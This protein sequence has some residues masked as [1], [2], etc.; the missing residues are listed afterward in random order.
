[1]DN[2]Q[3]LTSNIISSVCYLPPSYAWFCVFHYNNKLP[4]PYHIIFFLL[5][6]RLSTTFS[7][8]NSLPYQA[9]GFIKT[10]RGFPLEVGNLSY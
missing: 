6:N 8:T 10:I 2:I 9:R 4:H 5:Y 1:M 3:T 7:I